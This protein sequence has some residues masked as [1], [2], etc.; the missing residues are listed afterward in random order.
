MKIKHKNLKNLIAKES[1]AVNRSKHDPPHP[2]KNPTL[3][4]THFA[5]SCIMWLKPIHQLL[6]ILIFSHIN[7]NL[8]S[9]VYPRAAGGFIMQYS[10]PVT[11]PA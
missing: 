4:Q 11:V 5:V 7:E 6:W 1:L 2:L 10:V 3:A 8:H 9:N